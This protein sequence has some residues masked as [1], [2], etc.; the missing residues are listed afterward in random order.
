LAGSL[1]LPVA[2]ASGF[3]HKARLGDGVASAC[4]MLNLL[5]LYWVDPGWGFGS[6]SKTLSFAA[7]PAQVREWNS[8]ADWSISPEVAEGGDRELGSGKVVVFSD[9]CT[10]PGVLWNEHFTNRVIYRPMPHSAEDALRD[11]DD[12][13]ADWVIAGATS[14]YYQATQSRPEE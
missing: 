3:R 9:D 10:F 8:P 5:S 2:W 1:M 13:H 12:T 4:I 11:L 14:V 6:M 7:L